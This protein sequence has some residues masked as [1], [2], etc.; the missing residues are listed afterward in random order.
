M[1]S[2][3][4]SNS[5]AEAIERLELIERDIVENGATDFDV[6]M[7]LEVRGA[8]DTLEVSRGE[9]SNEPG[10]PEELAPESSISGKNSS[11]NQYF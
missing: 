4:F 8:V 2:Q 3:Q 11:I 7:A 5:L 10:R 6:F 1:A 9:G